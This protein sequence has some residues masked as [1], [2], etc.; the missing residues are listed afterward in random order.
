MGSNAFHAGCA[1][2]HWPPPTS[3]SIGE[4]VWIHCGVCVCVALLQSVSPDVLPGSSAP[5]HLCDGTDHLCLRVLYRRGFPVLLESRVEV[6]T[7]H[8]VVRVL[9][10]GDS[11]R[12]ACAFRSVPSA[13]AL[14]SL[15]LLPPN[16]GEWRHFGSSFLAS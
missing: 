2:L 3:Q 12:Y 15:H 5:E 8:F 13:A 1:E 14:Q 10:R 6:Q 9:L 4:E 16:P 11:L 7:L